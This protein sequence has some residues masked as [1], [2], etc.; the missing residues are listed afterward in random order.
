[1]SPISRPFLPR[2]DFFLRQFQ[3]GMRPFAAEVLVLTYPFQA[4]VLPVLGFLNRASC[5]RGWTEDERFSSSSG[6]TESHLLLFD[7]LA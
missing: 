7:G 2:S 5:D 4:A 3:D 6:S 1:M